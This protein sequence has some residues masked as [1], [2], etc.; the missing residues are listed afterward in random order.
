MR[1]L[2]KSLCVAA[3]A[4]L[5]MSAVGAGQPAFADDPAPDISPEGMARVQEEC[6]HKPYSVLLT[7]RGAK[8]A[9]G[10]FT[11]DLHG[12]KTKDRFLKYGNKIVRVWVAAAKGTSE[13]CVP[14]PEAGV[15]AVSV[16]QDRDV[17]FKF[18]KGLFGLPTEPYGV[19]ND[20][21]MSFGPPDFDD[22]SFKVE[23]PLTP[24]TITLFN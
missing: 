6:R 16:Y 2:A 17:N 8:T 18:N 19:S 9:K 10:I 1:V 3:V 24:T 23:G 15:Y 11:I 13:I 21:P 20:P 14:V 22:S 4:L 7:I 12:E 5:V